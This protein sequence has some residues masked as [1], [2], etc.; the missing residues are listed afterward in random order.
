MLPDALICPE[1][2]QK[3]CQFCISYITTYSALK[4][5]Y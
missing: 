1:Y 2:E 3:H 5:Y 4:R